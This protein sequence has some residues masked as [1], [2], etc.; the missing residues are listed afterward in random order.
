MMK[1][2]CIAQTEAQEIHTKFKHPSTPKF[3]DVLNVTM[4]V[5]DYETGEDYYLFREFGYWPGGCMFQAKFFAPED[6]DAVPDKF[7]SNRLDEYAR[8]HA[9]SF[10][11]YLCDNQRQPCKHI[12]VKDVVPSKSM[13]W[14]QSPGGVAV[15]TEVQYDLFI[16]SQSA[17]V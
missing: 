2:I 6:E 1:V 4:K 17:I 15:S 9:I 3:G 12:D 8:R 16:K 13:W 5:F 14:L 7:K 10:G 11:Q